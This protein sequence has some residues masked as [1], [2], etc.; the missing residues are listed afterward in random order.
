MLEVDCQGTPFEVSVEIPS[1]L[2]RNTQR[3]YRSVMSMAVKR[4]S[5]S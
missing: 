5:K 4:P 2:D 1:I 3:T